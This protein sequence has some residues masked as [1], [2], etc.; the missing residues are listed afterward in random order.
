MPEMDGVEMIKQIH[1]IDPQVPIIATSGF[2]DNKA[3]MSFIDEQQLPFLQKPYKLEDLL[4][5]IHAL[6]DNVRG[7]TTHPAVE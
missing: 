5:K 6:L 4:G 7:D 1:A 3:V 2:V